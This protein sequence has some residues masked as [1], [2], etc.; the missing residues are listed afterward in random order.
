MNNIEKGYQYELFINN[1]LNS[2]DNIKI[3][4]LWKNVPEYILFDYGFI[5]SY[6]DHRLQRKTNNINKL[7]DIGSDIIYINQK[8]ECI[9]VQCK[10]Y[11]KS[12][13][14]EDLSGFFFIMCKH[15]D[16]IGEIYYTNKISKKI[17]NEY[18][19]ND[20][21][22]LI[23]KEFIQDNKVIDIIKPYDYQ[24]KIIKLAEE[25]YKNNNTSI[26]SLPCGT[27]KTLISCYIAMNYKIVIIITPLKQYAKQNCDRFKIYENDRNSLLIDSDGSRDLTEINEFI[28]NNSKILLS[29]T[30][31]SCDII[32]EIIDKLENVFIIFD[33]FHNFSYNNIYDEENAIYKLINND[34]IKKLYLSATPKI[35]ELE[36]NNDIDVNEIFGDYIYKMS[37]N[38]AINNKYI[39]DYELYLPIF[40]NDSCNEEI[41][42]LN[43]HQ[44]YLLK[45]QF[46]IEAIKMCGNL[47]IIV[48]VR[49]HEEIDTFIS[50]FNKLNE[51]YVYN[52]NINKITC[53]DSYN[54]R[55]KILDNFNNSNKMNILLSVHILDE[56][57]DIPSCNAIYMSYVSN[58]KIK[59]IQ[60]MSRAMRYQNNKIAKVFLFCKDIDESISYISS[61]REY[62]TDFIKKINYLD[63]SDKIISKKERLII[64]NENIEKNKIK[65]LGI[66]LYRSENWHEK[67]EMVKKYIDENN[68]R[69]CM[70]NKNKYNMSLGQWIVSNQFKFKKGIMTNEDIYN[71][72]TKFI[73]DNKYKEYFEDTYTTWIRHLDCVKKYIDINKKRPSHTDITSISLGQWITQNQIKYS[74]KECIMKNEDIYN[75]W[76]EFINDNKYK[77]YFD[78]NITI[79]YNKLEELKKYIDKNN[80][81]P[82]NH[83]KT[84]D[85]KI[86]GAWLGQTINKY[87]Q[88]KEIMKNEDIYNTWIEFINSNKYNKYFED[89]ITI[90]KNN[91]KKLNEYIDLNKKRPSETDKNDDIKSLGKWICT[92]QLKYKQKK[93]I[94]INDEI[95][96][97]W[98]NFINDNKYKKYFEN[99]NT[100]WLN[101]LEELKI[102]IKTNNKR[103]SED[104]KINE[105]IK[106]LGK[107][108]NRQVGNYKQKKE[109]MKD[110]ELYNKWTE[111]INEYN[112]YF[113]DNKTIWNNSLE[114]VINYIDENN[115]IPS[116][117]DK[118]N[119]IKTLGNY[120]SVQK[121]NYKT[122]KYIM[123][124]E[125][126]YNKWTEFINDTKYKK[127]F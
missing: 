2:K 107:W 82:S 103:P 32:C 101:K 98:D 64:S 78:D 3:S 123:S 106:V 4:Y 24:N 46:L 20:R 54:K 12:I 100:M 121:Q 53:D 66:K 68:K 74:K 125:D 97:L 122:K 55:T 16:K 99:I 102:Y 35:Y 76:T 113:L 95:Y 79:W 67:L 27:G 77:E 93:Q 88:K 15:N 28:K 71:K 119:E 108:C 44:D 5:K 37:F 65:I 83:D 10:N 104:D 105:N 1:Y 9:I 120:L 48:Y 85:I 86:L 58:S 49:T 115:K 17:L 72:W 94:M 8:D 21:I 91:F 110:E 116:T 30:Y 47:K 63:I 40:S 18:D 111:F 13:K 6:N 57:I 38:E 52:V 117:I 75:K 60:R 33:E 34:N 73:N 29:V 126:I 89:N 45:L 36:D 51:Y 109:I 11:S 118:N 26:L 80:S 43:I 14:I 25:Y 41:N 62:D 59:N 22:K 87:K 84:N 69:P 96:N 61:I 19:D 7:E 124:N 50:E 112:Q 114:K 81:R 39:S 127:Y 56:A 90:W 23:K 70:K 31:K 42:N 92:T